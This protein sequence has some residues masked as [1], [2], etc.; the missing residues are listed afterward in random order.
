[1][2]AER[3]FS[4]DGPCLAR[5]RDGIAVTRQAVEIRPV[6]ARESFQP[7]ERPRRFECL[8]VE[9]ERCVRGIAAGAAASALLGIPGMRR[10]VGAQEEFGVA[11][12]CCFTSACRCSASRSAGNT[13]AAGCRLR[14][15]WRGENDGAESVG[16]VRGGGVDEL[17]GFPRRDVLEYDF[18]F[19][20]IAQDSRKHAL[21]EYALAIEYIDLARRHF[22]VDQERQRMFLHCFQHRIHTLD[23]SDT[24]SG[25]GRRPG[26]VVFHADDETAAPRLG[27]LRN[28]RGVGPMQR[29]QGAKRDAAGIA[30]AIRSR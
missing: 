19:R 9:L 27:D 17:D 23:R 21:D 24:G 11:A 20:K 15:A 30:A 28:R 4:G 22:S 7:V 1:M 16:D 10:R 5:E 12:G 14:S 3:V 29:Q 18:Q 2:R 6:K 8:G 13:N 26:G 25:V